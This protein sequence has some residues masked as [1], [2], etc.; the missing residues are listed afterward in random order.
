MTSSVK[1]TRPNRLT[2]NETLTTFEDWRT[3][4]EFY[5][6]QEQKFQ[7]FLQSNAT[8]EKSD[9]ASEHRCLESADILRNLNQFL[10]VIAALLPPLLHGDIIN[11][12]T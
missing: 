2:E 8:W 1:V 5:L 12:F 9:D 7:T 6:S 4:L 11:D 3:N 10:G